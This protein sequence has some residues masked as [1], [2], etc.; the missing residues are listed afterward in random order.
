L[1]AYARQYH[2]GI[3]GWRHTKELRDPAVRREFFQKC[4][5]LGLAGVKLDFF[6]HE[7]KEVVELYQACLREAAESKLLMNFHGANKPTGESRTWPNELTREAVK[8]MEA[9]K[10]QERARHNPTIP[11]TRLLAGHADYTPVHF[12]A[13]RGDTTWTHQ[14]A[15]AAIFTSPL[16]TYARRRADSITIELR[17]GGG[18]IGRFARP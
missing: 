14:L 5:E 3:W 1:V 2:V 13:R 7:G 12:G 16:M 11:F 17:A 15:S 9:S 10:L 18:F 4:Q 6:D 8:G